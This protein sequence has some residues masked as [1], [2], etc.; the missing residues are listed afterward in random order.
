MIQ[1]TCDLQVYFFVNTASFK[2]LD[3][4][5]QKSLGKQLELMKKLNSLHVKFAKSQA[6]RL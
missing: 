5:Q 3:K 2:K 1:T 4:E 6:E